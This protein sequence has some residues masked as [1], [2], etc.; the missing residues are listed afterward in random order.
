MTALP[1]AQVAREL[2]VNH[3]TLD[4]RVKA[5]RKSSPVSLSRKAYR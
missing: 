1:I 4:F 5:Y 3:T 2:E